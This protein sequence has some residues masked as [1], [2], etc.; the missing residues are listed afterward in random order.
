MLPGATVKLLGNGQTVETDSLGHFYFPVRSGQY[1]LA[2]Q[3]EGY[4][5]RLVSVTVPSDS[6]R[7]V[8]VMLPP[9]TKEMAVRQA[10]NIT[11]LGRRLSMHQAKTSTIF[12]HEDLERLGFSWISEA[13]QRGQNSAGNRFVVPAGCYATLDGGPEAVELDKLTIDEVETIEVYPNYSQNERPLQKANTVGRIV[14][15]KGIA[16]SREATRVPLS[17]TEEARFMNQRTQGR[18]RIACPVVYVWSR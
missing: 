16:D 8:T 11:D 1:M 18:V 9:R 15:K 6:G 7:N 3:H 10:G 12:T 4:A 13:A 2:V 5:D 14:G 17:N